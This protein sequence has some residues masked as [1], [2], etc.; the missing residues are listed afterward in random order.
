[1]ALIKAQYTAF[2]DVLGPGNISADP[3]ILYPYSWRSGLYA[4][5]EKFTPR[6]KLPYFLRALRRFR[7]SS[8]FVINSSCNL[9]PPVR[10]GDPDND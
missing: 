1:M 7:P 6:F 2:E 9:R 10:G 3:V 4:G 5:M 8:G